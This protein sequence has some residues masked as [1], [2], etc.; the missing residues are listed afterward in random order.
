MYQAELQAVDFIGASEETRQLINNWVEDKT[1]RED[2]S[3]HFFQC[4]SFIFV[5]INFFL[6]RGSDKI[7][8]LLK[9]GM[10]NASTQIALVNA[11]YFKGRWRNVFEAADTKE[12]PFKINKVR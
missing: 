4:T 11:I 1:E 12:M 6:L 2:R 5:F 7:K 8:D 10:I 3:V 9:P